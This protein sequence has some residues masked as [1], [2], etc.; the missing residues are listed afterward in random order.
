LRPR[1]G[2]EKEAERLFAD[3]EQKTAIYQLAVEIDLPSLVRN[4]V[5]MPDVSKLLG[6]G[7]AILPSQAPRWLRFPYLRLA[8]LLQTAALCKEYGIQAAKV[9]FGGVQLTNAAFGVQAAELRADDLAS[10]VSSGTYNSDLGALVQNDM[11]IMNGIVRFRTSA[12]G[13]AFRRQTG[14]ALVAESG[15]E[16]NASVN[17]GLSRKYPNHGSSE[18]PRQVADSDDRKHPDYAYSCG[19]GKR[20]AVR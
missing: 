9:P 4:A 6:I 19:L 7:D 11:S 13:E 8:H 14:Q 17:A 16:F 15:R 12:E 10:Y 18:S 2:Q 20:H 5:L 3:L 1:L